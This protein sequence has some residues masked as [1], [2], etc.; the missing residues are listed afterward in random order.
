MGMVWS[1]CN[2]LTGGYVTI[3]PTLTGPLPA[4]HSLQLPKRDD[5]VS[6]CLVGPVAPQ[7]EDDAP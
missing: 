6:H 2:S 4:D 1:H 5:E 3:H 7:L